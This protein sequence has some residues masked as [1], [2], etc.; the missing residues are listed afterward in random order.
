MVRLVPFID[1]A[2]WWGTFTS[3]VFVVGGLSGISYELRY[4][5]LC[6]KESIKNPITGIYTHLCVSRQLEWY[7]I[8]IKIIGKITNTSKLSI[9]IDLQV[10][11]KSL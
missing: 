1:N 11:Y 3:V 2:Y 8:A 7:T 6:I 5:I 4:I 9:G 10:K